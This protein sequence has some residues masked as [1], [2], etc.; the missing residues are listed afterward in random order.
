MNG[1]CVLCSVLL[2]YH[3]EHVVVKAAAAGTLREMSWSEG[4]ISLAKA[5]HMTQN[6]LH[7]KL[8]NVVYL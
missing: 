7:R 1:V 3:L 8:G 5:S 6:E 2:L 4:D